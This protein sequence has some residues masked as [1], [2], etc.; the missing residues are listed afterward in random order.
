[1]EYVNVSSK[2]AS[3]VA[4]KVDR[5]KERDIER[6]ND[7]KEKIESTKLVKAL[8]KALTP[9][10]KNCPL[11]IDLKLIYKTFPTFKTNDAVIYDLSGFLSDKKYSLDV[12]NSG[13]T[14]TI[15]NNN[16]TKVTKL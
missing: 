8:F 11:K 1:M 2:V 6:A 14:L 3:L 5:K 15:Q 4:V 9:Y 16:Y 12:E 7:K 13:Q 10:L